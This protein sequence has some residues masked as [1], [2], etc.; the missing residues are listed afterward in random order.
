MDIF[1]IGL[2]DLQTFFVWTLIILCHGFK[3]INTIISAKRGS[4]SL[5]NPSK[6]L[7]AGVNGTQNHSEL[8]YINFNT[9]R[10]EVIRFFF[11]YFETNLGLPSC[12][13]PSRFLSRGF[14]HR[15]GFLL[16]SR[17]DGSF[18][19]A[20]RSP[21]LGQ[22]LRMDVGQ[23]STC[24][25]GHTFEQL[26]QENKMLNSRLRVKLIGSFLF[27]KYQIM[28]ENRLRRS[29]PGSAPHRWQWP[30]G[31]VAVSHDPFY[32]LLLHFLPTPG[33]PLNIKRTLKR[34]RR[35]FPKN[36]L[37]ARLVCKAASEWTTGQ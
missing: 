36:N 17:R 14:L 12:L 15:L 33:S 22:Q 35:F 24:C 13:F 29:S 4:G 23:N 21:L 1:K 3:W 37:S 11:F 26:T 10:V 2:L 6:H 16:R 8:P 28:A 19:F 5:K 9:F 25:D 18:Q 32:C 34:T 20:L 7:T 30:A 31:C 27:K